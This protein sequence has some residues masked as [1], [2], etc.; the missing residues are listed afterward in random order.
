[1]P[2]PLDYSQPQP[3]RGWSTFAI[4]VAVLAAFVAVTVSLFIFAATFGGGI[5]D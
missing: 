1:M 4:V 2:E 3:R 5:T